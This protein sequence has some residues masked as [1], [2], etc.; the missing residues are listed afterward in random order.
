MFREYPLFRV[1]RQ[2]DVDRVYSCRSAVRG[3]ILAARLA[4]PTFP[5]DKPEHGT[6]AGT[7]GYPQADPS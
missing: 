4:K 3:S 2:T 5:K 6:V 7:Q 1:T